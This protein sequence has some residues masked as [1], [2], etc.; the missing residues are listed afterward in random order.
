MLDAETAGRAVAISNPGDTAQT[1]TLTTFGVPEVPEPAG[2]KGSRSR[3]AGTLEGD[4]A[5]PATV[6]QGT[7]LVAVLEITPL[8]QQDARLMVD[9][10]LPAGFEID[11]PNLIRGG[12][13]ATLD[14]LGVAE[15]TEM[16]EFRQDR[17]LAAIDAHG[18]R[19]FRLAYIVR[20]VSPGRFHLQRPQFADVYRPEMRAQSDAGEVV[21]E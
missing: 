20:A 2:G 1:L 8:G 11:N 6:K 7:R 14:W 10:P 3:A 13:I 21:I 12:D 18:D 15:D 4:P 19:P 9:D 16:T 5:D 17:F